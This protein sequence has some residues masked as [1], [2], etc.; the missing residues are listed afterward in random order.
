MALGQVCPLVYAPLFGSS[1]MDLSAVNVQLAG[2]VS[3]E[4]LGQAE[5][6][7]RPHIAVERNAIFP[8]TGQNLRVMLHAGTRGAMMGPAGLGAELGRAIDAG[9]TCESD[10]WS[11]LSGLAEPSM[12]AAVRGAARDS[13]Y[14]SD[15]SRGGTSDEDDE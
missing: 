5:V 10:L 3:K 9:L 12:T 8:K 13:D 4:M 14:D 1:Q 7:G 2:R 11:L 6:T 15:M